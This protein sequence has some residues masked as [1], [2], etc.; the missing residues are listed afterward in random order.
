MGCLSRFALLCE[1]NFSCTMKIT[2][3]IGKINQSAFILADALEAGGFD[4]NEA[5]L[6]SGY[7]TLDQEFGQVFELPGSARHTRTQT[8]CCPESPSKPTNLP[9]VKKPFSSPRCSTIL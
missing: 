6:L 5:G 3:T 8:T 9:A 4:A 1:V 7:E 2:P